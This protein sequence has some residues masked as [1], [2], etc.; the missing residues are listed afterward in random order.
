MCPP[1]HLTARP[2]VHANK[3]EAEHYHDI[4]ADL[5][6]FRNEAQ[7][8]WTSLKGHFKTVGAQVSAVPLSAGTTDQTYTADPAFTLVNDDLERIYIVASQ[9]SNAHRNAEVQTFLT[10]LKSIFSSHPIYKDY[11]CCVHHMKTSFEGTGDN[12]YD[13][14]RDLIFSGYTTHLGK[15]DPSQGRSS[16]TSHQT[17]SEVTGVAVISLEVQHPC[18]HIDTCLGFLPDGPALVYR[19]G[20]TE[21]AFKNL[22]QKA[23]KDFGL[24]PTK[25]II[26]VTQNE[27]ENHFVTNLV[28]IGNTVFIP[29]FGNG[30]YEPVRPAFKTQLSALGYDIKWT[31]MSAFIKVGGAVHC[32][33]HLLHHRVLGGLLRK[34]K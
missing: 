25:C 28:C 17:L 11:E 2:D 6:S 32:T 3:K 5:S 8:Q 34:E 15:N 31:D 12:I 22:Q 29:H 18:F 27:A 23:F 20:M 21:N 7:Q 9:F 26:E 13:P 16:I 30:N 1:N 14:Y 4:T 19:A 33:S 10:H 24:D